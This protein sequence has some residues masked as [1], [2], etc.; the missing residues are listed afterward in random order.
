MNPDM[1]SF[2][3]PQWESV[4]Q[5]ACSGGSYSAVG[6]L[7]LLE[8]EDETEVENAFSYLE[9]NHI[10][11]N[12]QEM[13]EDFGSGE[14]QQRLQW[15]DKLVR[16]GNV[17]ADLDKDDP[18]RL[19]LE[20]LASIPAAGDPVQLMDAYRC[21]DEDALQRLVNATISKAVESAFQLTG[22]GVLLLD[23]IQEAS[24]GLWQG[25]LHYQEGE[26]LP[27]LQ[28]WID[29]YLA[30]ACIMQ[31][32]ANGLGSKMRKALEGYRDTDRTLLTTLG[33]NPT[34]EEIALAMGINPEEAEF[35]ED[36]LRTARMLD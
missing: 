11:L 23:L 24:L 28:W 1:F 3:V 12:M 17:P 2:D 18:L 10:A 8:G 32:R 5:G 13:P 25:I 30:K 29:F 9:S 35:Y 21:G 33:R 22:R 6:F 16:S 7:T 15:E 31:A 4:L 20:D 26:L 34:V 27:C 36:M 14:L 19:Y